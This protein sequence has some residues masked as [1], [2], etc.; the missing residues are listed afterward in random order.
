MGKMQVIGAAKLEPS[1]R[2]ASVWLR[3][4]IRLMVHFAGGGAEG[5][6]GVRWKICGF[7]VSALFVWSLYLVGMGREG[8]GEEKYRP[9]PRPSDVR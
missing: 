3:S 8:R 2:E 5:G 1:S 9:S 4:L 7:F 6:E